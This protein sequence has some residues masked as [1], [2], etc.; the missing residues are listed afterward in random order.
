[1]SCLPS[2]YMSYVMLWRPAHERFVV[3]V[4]S[5]ERFILVAT[6]AF[7]WIAHLHVTK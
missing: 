3:D 2:H 7:E 5:Y 4:Y 1:M 6:P